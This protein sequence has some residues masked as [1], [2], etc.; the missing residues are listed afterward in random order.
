M[1]DQG[2]VK[3]NHQEGIER[4]KQRASE[5]VNRGQHGKMGVGG[6]AHW[7]RSEHGSMTPRKA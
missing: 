5:K 6:K 4:V 3:D 2:K 7:S 1:K